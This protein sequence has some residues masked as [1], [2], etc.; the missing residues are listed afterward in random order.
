MLRTL[1]DTHL[2]SEVLP[3]HPHPR[4]H[5][6]VQDPHSK[7]PGDK[8]ETIKHQA[9]RDAAHTNIT[10]VVALNDV[11]THDTDDQPGGLAWRPHKPVYTPTAALI[12]LIQRRELQGQAHSRVLLHRYRHSQRLPRHL[13][14]Y[15]KDSHGKLGGMTEPRKNE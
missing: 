7:G 3:S 14:Q 5:R 6:F 4:K 9:L 15:C 10:C 8:Q 13:H 2:P 12:I 1:V 11:R